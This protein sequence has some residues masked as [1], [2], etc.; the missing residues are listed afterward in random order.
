MSDN[1]SAELRRIRRA[2]VRQSDALKAK[3]NQI[4]NAERTVLQDAIV[5]IRNGRYVIPVKQEHKNRVPGIIHDQS[6]SGATLFIEPQTIV[7]MNNELRELRSTG[8]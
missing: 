1:A 4:L 7:N 8:F 2:Q 6:G 3:M 5:T